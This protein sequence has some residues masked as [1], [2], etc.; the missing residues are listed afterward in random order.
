MPEHGTSDEAPVVLLRVRI[1]PI[2]VEIARLHAL[3]RGNRVWRVRA[4]S[5]LAEEVDHRFVILSL[6]ICEWSEARLVC[7][8]DTKRDAVL[9]P[10]RSPR[11]LD[12]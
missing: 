4:R 7:R 1:G 11:V 2:A 6:G 9:V 3:R 8:P 5:V 10:R 12:Q